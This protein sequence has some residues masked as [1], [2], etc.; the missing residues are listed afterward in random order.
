MEHLLQN[1]KGLLAADESTTT[2]SKRFAAIGVENTEENRRAYRALLAETPG[3]HAYIHGVILHEETFQQHAA[4]GERITSIFEE[5][6]IITG[7]KVDQGLDFFPNSEHE[8]ITL[9]LDGLSARLEH[10]KAQGARFAKWRNVYNISDFTPSHAAV[11]TGADTLARYAATCQANGIVP[12]VEPEVLMD[13]IHSIED[14]ADATEIV[15]HELFHALFLHRVELELMILKPNM[16]ISGKDNIPS[17]CAED[18]ADY[19]INV[20]RNTIPAAVP[21]IMFLSGGQTPQQATANL[22]AMQQLDTQPWQLSFSYGRALQEEC[23]AKWAG[24]N[25]QA[26]QTALL[27]RARLLHLACLGEYDSAMEV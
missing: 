1:G 4:N 13:G 20:F 8:K 19:T 9:G 2:L 6:G 27:H 18:V 5:Q 14:C 7:I 24:H 11:R 3:L 22:N 15:L 23:L 16:I 26:A 21:A 17:S 10:F 25:H 12:V